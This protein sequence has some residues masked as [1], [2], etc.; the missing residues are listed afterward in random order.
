MLLKDLV[1]VNQK[2]NV[3]NAVSFDLMDD[4]DTNQDLCDSFIFNYDPKS[5]SYRRSAF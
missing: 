4:P 3:A 1:E 5:Q 2:G